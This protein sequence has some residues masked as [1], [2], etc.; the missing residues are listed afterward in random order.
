M[1]DKQEFVHTLKHGPVP[2]I[3]DIIQKKIDAEREAGWDRKWRVTGWIKAVPLE[4][5][6]TN[7]F[8]TNLL[9]EQAAEQSGHPDHVMIWCHKHEATHVTGSGV[10][11]CMLRIEEVAVVG[12]VEW[13][14]DQI[15]DAVESHA[16]FIGEYLI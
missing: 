5:V 11:G 15:R 12:R 14:E 3:G 1:S 4:D 16:R 6:L 9:L 8:I 13:S 10:A 2:D 7:N